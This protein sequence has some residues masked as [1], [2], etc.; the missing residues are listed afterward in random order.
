MN[1]KNKGKSLWDIVNRE[2]GS[3]SKRQYDINISIND[4]PITPKEAANAFN[5][6]FTNVASKTGH[7]PRTV[8]PYIEKTI[9]TYPSIF[10]YPV[11]L[12]ETKK[13][14]L[15]L[16]NS[17]SYANPRC[18]NKIMYNIYSRAPY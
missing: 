11:T 1:S 10:L 16:K 12:A 2:T 7:V 4:T 6:Y 14:I 9:L 3:K 13:T 17:F 15:Q 18:Y 8:S 5:N